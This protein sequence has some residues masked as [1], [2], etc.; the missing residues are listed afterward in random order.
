[1]AHKDFATGI[2]VTAPSPA[3]SGTS[4]TLDSGQGARFDGSES[5][6]ATAHP[7]GTL[8]T[9]DTAEVVLVTAITTDTF[10]ITRAQGDTTA[11]SIAIGWRVTASIYADEF[12]GKQDK[13]SEG[14]FADGDKTKL[15]GIEAS[16]DVTDTANVTAA[17]ALMDSEVDADIKTLSLPANT[18]ISTFG[19]S[20]VDDAAASNARTTLDVYSTTEVDAD[21]ATKVTGD[22]T[23]KLT[24]NTAAPSTPADGDLW[25]DTDDDDNTNLLNLVLETIYQVGSVF[26][27]GSP[28]LPAAID[29]IGT[30]ARI[31]GRFIV[32]V[33]DSDTDFDLNDTGGA[34]THTLDISE[35]P[36]KTGTITAHSSRSSFWTPSGVF[37]GSSMASTYSPPSASTGGANSINILQ[38]NLGGGG[39]AHNNL[40]PYKAKYMWERVS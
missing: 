26:V 36:N 15:D 25:V 6:Y 9:L 17:G 18:T 34:K 40:P 32:G 4:L 1:M 7:E 11:K 24:V 21:L 35:I 23:A 19:A 5:F 38:F 3:T 39:G 8:P 22:G 31:E 33:S 29:A 10:T 27:S 13:P 28:T 2:V 20:L 12:D 37:S 30:W 16:A 14:A